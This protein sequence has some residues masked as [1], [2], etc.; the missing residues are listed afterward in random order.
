MSPADVSPADVSPA[1]SAPEYSPFGPRGPAFNRRVG[2]VWAFVWLGYLAYPIVGLAE[3]RDSALHMSLTLLVAAVGVGC[4]VSLFTRQS[5]LSPATAETWAALAGLSAVAVGLTVFDGPDW[6]YLLYFVGTG[7]GMLLATRQFVPVFVAAL[8]ALALVLWLTGSD[9]AT[10]GYSAGGMFGIGALINAFRRALVSNLA[11][12][13]AREELARLAVADERL[14]FA[15]DLHDLLGHSLSVIALKAELAGRLLGHSPEQAAAEVAASA[16]VAA[17]EVADIESVARE[18]LAEVREAVGGYRQAGLSA[19][20]ASARSALAAAGIELRLSGIHDAALTPEV[21]E[22]A[23]WV[24]REGT[25]NVVRHSS[26][27]SCSISVEV[28]TEEVVVAVA[29]NGAGGR[30]GPDGAGGRPSPDGAGGS[31]AKSGAPVRGEAGGGHGLLGLSERVAA[32]G[33]RLRAGGNEGSGFLLEATIPTGPG[34]GAGAAGSAPFD[35]AGTE[36]TPSVQSR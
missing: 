23:A 29:D 21:E 4:Y 16:G 35:S 9:P 7:A 17:A 31:L 18:A 19:E 22:A 20:V 3:S 10:I 34:A 2:R 6:V 8:G 15:R 12:H 30:A 36:P 14:R 1:D 13:T 32:I 26:A 25:T 33:G 5:P 27:S 11:L 28:G 24:L